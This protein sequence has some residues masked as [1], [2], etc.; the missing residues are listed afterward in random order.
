MI[1][2]Y[3]CV[4]GEGPLWHPDDQR[5]YWTDIDSGRLFQYDPETGAHAVIRARRR[6]LNSNPSDICFYRSRYA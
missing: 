3:A 1:A 2:D 4:V 6:V 5:V